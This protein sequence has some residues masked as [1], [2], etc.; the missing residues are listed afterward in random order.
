MS[1]MDATHVLWFDEC[2]DEAT[3]RFDS[4]IRAGMEAD[5]LIVVGTIGATPPA[6]LLQIAQVPGIPIDINP[7]DAPSPCRSE[8]SRRLARGQATEKMAAVA[9]A[10]LSA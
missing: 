10:I 6:K 3:Y 2:Y 5:V 1:G 7:D 9:S 8:Q 4:T